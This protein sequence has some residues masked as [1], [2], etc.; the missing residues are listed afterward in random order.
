MTASAHALGRPRH[1]VPE[2]ELVGHAELERPL[3][4]AADG[5]EG[6]R[7]LRAQRHDRRRSRSATRTA[8]SS[9]RRCLRARA[10]STGCSTSGTR[11]RRSTACSS[12][13]SAPGRGG[14]TSTRPRRRRS[15][16]TTAGCR[17][18]R[19]Y[20]NRCLMVEDGWDRLAASFSGFHGG[21][22]LMAREFDWPGT[23]S[24]HGNWEPYPLA[25]WLFHDKV[26]HVPA[27][28]VRGDDDRRSGDAD[29]EPRVRARAVVLVGRR[30]PA[31][32]RGSGSPAR[33]SGRSGRSTPA[34]SCSTTATSRDNVTKSVFE[35]GL[36]VTANW[37]GVAVRPSSGRTIAPHG[38]VA[39]A[40]TGRSV[41]AALGS[42]WSGV[43][44]PGGSR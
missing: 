1:A 14:A 6:R 15:R 13:S 3:A 39:Q 12:T 36:T 21:V 11:T 33:S 28:P 34:A 38:F 42:T 30:L 20:A 32:A 41:A 35:G 26:L 17:C 10:G 23:H 2:R 19:P 25:D 44:F 8:T 18:S 37:S 40:R 4:A 22:M 29:V 43:T 16:T 27:R 9:L 5:A 31:R 24:G 7:R